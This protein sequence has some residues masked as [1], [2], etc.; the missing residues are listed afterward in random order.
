MC[1]VQL[2][3]KPNALSG[4]KCPLKA[5][6]FESQPVCLAKGTPHM[7]SFPGSQRAHGCPSESSR[8]PSPK[9][10]R[11]QGLKA[12]MRPVGEE[13]TGKK[14]CDQGSYS[15]A[16]FLLLPHVEVADSTTRRNTGNP[17][18]L[19]SP[20]NSGSQKPKG[21]HLLGPLKGTK[22]GSLPHFENRLP[23]AAISV[24]RPR[25]AVDRHNSLRGLF[26]TM[27]STGPMKV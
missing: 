17:G 6:V 12:W 2:K 26:F 9:R 23:Q 13:G 4:W 21:D 20:Q 15:P 24:F 3:A 8:K 25:Q 10:V 18:V 27:Q 22:H 1:F 19:C 5:V 7:V 14:P 11:T 16:P